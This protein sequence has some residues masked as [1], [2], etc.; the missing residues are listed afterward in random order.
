MVKILDT[1]LL[2]PEDLSSSERLAYYNCMDVFVTSAVFEKISKDLDQ[3]TQHIYS[4]SRKLQAPVL[5]M[6]T[7]GVLVDIQA[8]HEL[9]EELAAK[10]SRLNTILERFARAVNF[11]NYFRNHAFEKLSEALADAE[12]DP[13]LLD[14]AE[15]KSNRRERTSIRKANR[16][17][18]EDFD[19]TLKAFSR[20]FNG[21]S[22]T[23][24]CQLLYDMSDYNGL[25][26]PFGLKP[27]TARSKTTGSVRP[28]AD[29]ESLETLLKIASN[30]TFRSKYFWAIPFIKTIL[31]LMDLAKER[32]FLKAKLSPSGRFHCNFGIA[33]TNTGRFNSGKNPYDL[34]AN[35]QN[36]PE[37]LR[38]IFIADPGYKLS[39]SDL[40]QAESRDVGAICF[41]KFS[42]TRGRSF[43]AVI[44]KRNGKT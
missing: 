15:D 14:F 29:R 24:K 28:T 23:Q 11:Q 44:F 20:P 9:D 18:L 26:G 1:A 25:P 13:N 36:Y 40:E 43:S 4:H 12:L 34:G 17:A 42:I 38:R 10:I 31:S 22:T 37:A 35:F 7:N 33:G 19:K 2:N 5:E 16:K 27:I 30:K 6:M 39:Y 32:D 21:R 3:E 41:T 8:K